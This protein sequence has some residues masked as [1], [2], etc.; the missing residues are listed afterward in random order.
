MEQEAF[1]IREYEVHTYDTDVSRHLSFVALSN[2]LQDA[3]A[4]HAIRLQLGYTHLQEKQLAW[5]LRQMRV[6]T[7]GRAEWGDTVRIETWP[8]RPDRLFAHRD[9]RVYNGK[10]ELIALASTAWLLIDTGKRKHIMMDPAMFRHYRFRDETV[11]PEG[12][13]SLP[14]PHDGEEAARRE[15]AFSDLDMNG[16][17]NNVSYIRWIMDAWEKSDGKTYPGSFNI[18]Y[19]HEVFG[20]ARVIL[21][22]EQV[23]EGVL[24][25]VGTEEAKRA[26][27]ALLT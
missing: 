13:P 15:V 10:D 21:R 4:T 24:F 22:K 19:G 26:V 6:E 20:G 11:F 12:M 1:M 25:T 5:V 17:V 9:F 23:K 27:T 14:R 18:V 8:R 7:K 3:A 2:Y 16:H